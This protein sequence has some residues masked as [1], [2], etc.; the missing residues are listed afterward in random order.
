MR[1]ASVAFVLTVLLS[2]ASVADTYDQMPSRDTW[3]WPGQGPFG[4]SQQLR[5]NNIAVFD[6]RIVIGFDLSS[7][8]Q[9]AL[10]NSASLNIYRFDG[11][12]GSAL[13]C[14]IFRVT[15]DWEEITLVD[16]IAYD[17]SGPYDQIV[18][19]GNGWYVFDLTDLVQEW[20]QGTHPNYGAVFFGTGGTGLY[21]YF[22][23]R[24]AASDNPHLVVEYELAGSFEEC[25]FGSIKASYR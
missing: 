14:H 11:S 4:N 17:T 2:A 19:T 13:E 12:S 15:E 8:P 16:G 5:T 21:Q 24:E 9:D 1:G 7:I 22:H 18:I 20:V 23:S 25:T 3:V 10:V 6:Q